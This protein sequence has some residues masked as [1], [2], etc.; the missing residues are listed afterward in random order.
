[1]PI[2]RRIT[3]DVIADLGLSAGSEFAYIRLFG[4]GEINPTL[5]LAVT[6]ERTTIGNG[7]TIE[8]RVTSSEDFDLSDLEWTLP[9]NFSMNV[10]TK[11]GKGNYV[12]ELTCS[13]TGNSGSNYDI[14]LKI[15]NSQYGYQFTTTTLTVDNE[16]PTITCDQNTAGVG[17]LQEF[18]VQ[19]SG[20]W[21]DTYSN[22][23]HIKVWYE[24]NS[25]GTVR[26]R[27]NATIN[28][29]G[30]WDASI[31]FPEPIASATISAEITDTCGNTTTLSNFK[32]YL[33]RGQD[34]AISLVIG[35]SPNDAGWYN[36]EVP[37]GIRANT[38]F[39]LE[40]KVW[41]ES[42]TE[43][44]SWTTYVEANILDGTNV[45]PTVGGNNYSITTTGIWN[46]KVRAVSSIDS[47]NVKYDA[48][49]VNIDIEDPVWATPS[50]G[51]LQG[52]GA[53]KFDW[54][55]ENISSFS[56]GNVIILKRNQINDY[57]S[58]DVV[59]TV[60]DSVRKYQDNDLDSGQYYYF[61]DVRSR[62]GNTATNVAS[63]GALDVDDMTPSNLT[64]ELAVIRDDV[65][66]AHY[67]MEYGVSHRIDQI[68]LV[69]SS[70]AT[71]VGVE[72]LD[73]NGTWQPVPALFVDGTAET[74][75]I[76][77]NFDTTATFRHEFQFDK[78]DTKGV[79]IEF[80]DNTNAS[81]TSLFN[82]V[83]SLAAETFVGQTFEAQRGIKFIN[84]LGDS[85]ITIDEIGIRGWKD[86]GEPNTFSLELDG[87]LFA[88]Y[89]GYTGQAD[90]YLLFDPN[91]GTL[92]VKGDVVADNLTI[93]TDFSLGNT[94]TIAGTG[95]IQSTAWSI[96][97]S[98]FSFAGGVLSG[99]TS[100]ITLG[101]WVVD[102]DKLKS[103]TTGNA[104]IDLLSN[105]SK[106]LR[107]GAGATFDDLTPD[108]QFTES[109]AT[110]FSPLTTTTPSTTKTQDYNLTT[111]LTGSPDLSKILTLSF[112]LESWLDANL[113]PSGSG[114]TYEVFLIAKVTSGSW[115][116]Q[117]RLLDVTTM[118]AGAPSS[119]PVVNTGQATKTLSSYD[120]IGFR[121]KIT[122][123]R[124]TGDAAG[125]IKNVTVNQYR[126]ETIITEEGVYSLIAPG[127]VVTIGESSG[128]SSVVELP[129]YTAGTGLSLSS[130][131]FSIDSTLKSNWDSA[132]TFTQG[133]DSF[134]SSGTY[135]GL[136]VGNANDA[137]T[138]DNV[139]ASEFLRSNTNDTKTSGYTRFNDGTSIQLGSG[140]DLQM[141]FS[142]SHT[143][144]RNYNHTNGD[145]YFQGEDSQGNNQALFYLVT[146]TSRPYLRLFENGAER[147]RTLS[148]GIRVYGTSQADNHT[149]PSDIRLKTNLVEHDPLDIAKHVTLY[150]YNKRGLSYAQ[151]GII[152][153]D[154]MKYDSDLA[155]AYPDEEFGSIYSLSG[156][157]IA[158][159]ALS[160]VGKLD[161][162]V[163][164]QAKLISELET[165]IKALEKKLKNFE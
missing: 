145:I 20:T 141:N 64:D 114:V 69:T 94:M 142:G 108:T 126:V 71:V 157:S 63:S 11:V 6:P 160:G 91:A 97:E 5:S 7:N 161:Y 113:G 155:V 39:T 4:E 32:E 149:D 117:E 27:K 43:P 121:L 2:A 16:A 8:L 53:V 100:S 84:E 81:T 120:E 38:Q 151:Y 134:N 147:L 73:T 52:F 15:G 148:S 74:N 143:Y 150:K 109:L 96:E 112:D 57:A 122:N 50:L 61:V 164:K 106:G 140:G 105:G 138:V 116:E 156:Y 158:S 123:N 14:D 139:H 44:G 131:E 42:D 75:P 45:Q 62:A 72:Y 110:P 22:I 3:Q 34:A 118:L 111:A 70:V 137:D 129:E 65:D 9:A 127:R 95:S 125:Q 99:D 54:N 128:S 133:S 78:V 18:T 165:K 80:L 124:T 153:Q 89:Q 101:G 41:K 107:L 24:H 29:D 154:I 86:T 98:A 56:G 82:P 37:W 36:S 115:E 30:T 159:I 102:P 135:S 19:L 33:I 76:S 28:E 103:P 119:S 60:E 132:Y 104:Y 51:P 93:N 77:G 23:V 163:E 88:G 13:V 146:S 162:K 17:T 47:T 66:G 87:T 25:D 83:E 21:S 58:A 26:G 48:A 55:S 130:G 85:A 67:V 90:S 144:I 46:I 35:E 59:A 10:G 49:Q 79:R 31:T 40:Y 68:E 12:F 92:K 136:T 152:A 1:M